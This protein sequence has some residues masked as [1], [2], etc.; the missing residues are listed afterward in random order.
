MYYGWAPRRL[1]HRYTSVSSAAFCDIRHFSQK[2][3]SKAHEH[4]TQLNVEIDFA[5]TKTLWLL[6][7]FQ[8]LPSPY[9]T[10]GNSRSL[11][12]R[13]VTAW[14]SGH[15]PRWRQSPAGGDFPRPTPTTPGGSPPTA[16]TRPPSTPH[17]PA[18][19]LTWEGTGPGL[20]SR[21]RERA[22]SRRSRADERAQAAPTSAS[23]RKL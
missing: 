15:S 2:L 16:P 23:L 18:Q 12:I 14:D 22:A 13:P 9:Q 20:P 8:R 5:F 7:S 17:S 21:R 10:A 1:F 6:S 11:G 19:R 4:L 3:A